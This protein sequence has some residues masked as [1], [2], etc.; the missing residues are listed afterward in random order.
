MLSTELVQMLLRKARTVA[1]GKQVIG[2]TKLVIKTLSGHTTS[3]YGHPCFLGKEWYDWALVHFEEEH[4]SGGSQE[5]YYPSKV[6]GFIE[7]DGQ[8]EAIIQSS[9]EPLEWSNVQTKILVGITLGN[10]FDI[11]FVTVPIDSLVHPLCVI[12][13]IGGEPSRYFVVLPKSN[14]S[15]YFGD[16]INTNYYS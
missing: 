8:K 16:R 15:R 13:D 7:I 10:D 4:Q 11:S 9:L 6:I 5:H 12:P 1:I 3:F 2:Y 14:W